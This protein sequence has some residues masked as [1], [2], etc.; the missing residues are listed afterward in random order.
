MLMNVDIHT[1]ITMG[2]TLASPFLAVFTQS[3]INK[4]REVRHR[5]LELFKTL[6]TGVHCRS[7]Q[8]YIRAF[9]LIRIEFSHEKAIIDKWQTHVENIARPIPTDAAGEAQWYAEE[10]DSLY[11]LLML[12]AKKIDFHLDPLDL[13]QANYWNK[14]GKIEVDIKQ[15]LANWLT[16]ASKPKLETYVVE[17]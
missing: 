6:F 13:Q 14:T 12:I 3:W 11:E 17:P 15:G 9:R 8:F 4:I 1:A 10:E 2:A 16:G 7:E 5:R